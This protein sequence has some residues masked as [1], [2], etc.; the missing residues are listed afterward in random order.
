MSILH[1]LITFFAISLALASD[2]CPEATSLLQVGMIVQGSPL[3]QHEQDQMSAGANARS[4]QEKGNIM[5]LEGGSETCASMDNHGTY[6]SINVTIGEANLE[7]VVQ[8]FPLVADTGSNAIV[9]PDCSCKL[10]GCSA[11]LNCFDPN[12]SSSFKLL[13]HTDTAGKSHTTLEKLSYG[14]GSIVVAVA[15]DLVKVGGAVANMTKG[16]YLMVDRRQL[17]IKGDFEGILGLGVPGS[18]DDA[19]LFAQASSVNTYTICFNE[20]KPGVLKMNVGALANPMTN[21]GEVHWGLD[22]QGMSVG[23]E[24]A[25][26][27]FCNPS[28]KKPYMKTACG[29]IPDSG[30]TLMLGA[31][32][33]VLKLQATICD[34]WPRCKNASLTLPAPAAKAEVFNQL[35]F[36][37]DNWLKEN[38]NELSTMPPIY[39]TLA[40]AEGVPQKI[41]LPATAYVLETEQQL[42]KDIVVKIFGVLPVR[43]PVRTGKV[44]KVCMSA[45]DVHEYDTIH[46]GPVWILGTPLFY[47]HTL[48]YDIGAV[49]PKISVESKPCIECGASTSLTNQ[50][51]VRASL[52]KVKGPL[53]QKRWSVSDKL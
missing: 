7:E 2:E 38:P 1:A 4:Q 23:N 8:T 51:A 47:T 12:K 41:E 6:F 14:S 52:R 35:L 25:P 3:L 30:T 22:L 39:I 9:V 10:R 36:A 48:G 53:R 26:S 19:P 49:P 24:S 15:S 40:G 34:Q 43:I 42:F 29:A 21:I 17:L 13:S 28:S 44:G 16:V 37:C 33:Q 27:L 46:N 31:R 18:P 5:A 11:A 45:F 32:E 50:E 20:A